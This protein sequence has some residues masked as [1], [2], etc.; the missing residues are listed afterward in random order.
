ELLDEFGQ[1]ASVSRSMTRD[2]A[3]QCLSDLAARTAFQPADDDPSVTISPVLAAPVVHYDAL[4]VAGLHSEAFP[5]PVQP[6]PFLCLA[7]QVTKGV[8][9]ASAAGRLA[10]AQALVQ[11][12]RASTDDLVLSTAMRSED[13]ELLPSPLL[14][15]WLTAGAPQVS[16]WLPTRL[17]REGWLET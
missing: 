9:A 6:D 15:P 7:A 13:L 5:Q 4:W 11:S 8:P 14:R 17:H 1:L 12:W 16:V 3:V 10:E 2:Q